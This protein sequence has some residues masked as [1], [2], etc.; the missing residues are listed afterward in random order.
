MGL[1]ELANPRNLHGIDRAAEKVEDAVAGHA[2]LPV[3]GTGRAG[4]PRSYAS[5]AESSTAGS[6]DGS[7]RG[8]RK[9]LR[10]S[11][12][13]PGCDRRT[14]EVIALAQLPDALARVTGVGRRGDRPERVAGLHAVGSFGPDRT[15]VA[16]E[17]RPGGQGDEC[18]ENESSEHVFS[19]MHEH[20]FDVKSVRSACGSTC[21]SA[22][23]SIR[24]PR[25][26]RR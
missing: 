6:H 1:P 23:Y 9:R 17:K 3:A 4:S 21:S 5:S 19:I 7:A 11:E 26:P 14:G 18:D 10:K 22:S 16:G 2:C 15:G 24:P 12:E 13:L 25:A 8:G 20:L